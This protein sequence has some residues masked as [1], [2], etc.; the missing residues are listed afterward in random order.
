[1]VPATA[2]ARVPDDVRATHA[3]P[4][5]CAGVTVFGA[6]RRGGARPGDLV[7]IVGPGGLGHL[8]ARF[9]AKMG[10]N[11]VVVARGQ[12]KAPLAAE[13]QRPGGARVVL[14]TAANSE[15]MAHTVDG[16]APNGELTVVGRQ[17]P[18]GRVGRGRHRVED[19][20]LA[21]HWNVLHDETTRAESVSGLPMYGDRFPDE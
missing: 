14:A 8:A 5:A 6:P 10:P 21:E 11:T 16:L 3:A 17:R 2:L 15:A 19:G 4:M 7:A 13:L 20:R 18:T 1:V 9:A 12:D